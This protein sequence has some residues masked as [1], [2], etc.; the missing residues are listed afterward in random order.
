MPNYWMLVTTLENYRITQGLGFTVQGVKAKQR[1][2]AQRMQQGDRVLYYL[3]FIQ[4]FPAIA[5]ITAPF[6]EEHKAI[7]KPERGRED[8][9]Y[10]VQIRPDI[11]L[12]EEEYLD[13]HQLGPG[14]HYVRRWVPEDWYLAFQEHLHLLPQR[15]FS[16]IYEEMRKVARRR[17]VSAARM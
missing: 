11:V 6:W 10:R 3:K 13:A 16:L 7:W 15:D 9:P 8:F 2:K 5:T 17:E 12:E 1:K 4:K 14:L